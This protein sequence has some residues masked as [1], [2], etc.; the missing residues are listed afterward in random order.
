MKRLFYRTIVL[1]AAVA[2]AA[3]TTSA[4]SAEDG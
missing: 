3:M 1:F 2:I 4:I